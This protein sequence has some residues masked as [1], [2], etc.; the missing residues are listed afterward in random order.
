MADGFEAEWLRGAVG[1]G[2]RQGVEKETAAGR[3]EEG[4]GGFSRPADPALAAEEF[5][6]R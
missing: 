2:R 4:G 5:L 1:A 6:R 3:T